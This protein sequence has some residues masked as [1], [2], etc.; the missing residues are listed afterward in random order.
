MTWNSINPA[1]EPESSVRLAAHIVGVAPED[2]TPTQLANAYNQVETPQSGQE[3]Q[4]KIDQ[5]FSSISDLLDEDAEE[6]VE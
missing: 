2:I 4:V 5:F 3:D 6:V 1:S